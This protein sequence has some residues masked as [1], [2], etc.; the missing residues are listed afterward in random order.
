MSSDS[1]LVQGEKLSNASEPCAK[2]GGDRDWRGLCPR[3]VVETVLSNGEPTFE[4]GP[5]SKIGRYRLIRELGRGGMGRVFLAYQDDLRREVALKM[6]HSGIGPLAGQRFQREA[7][8][9]SRLRHPGIISIYEIGEA[10]GGMFLAMEYVRGQTLAD[11]L[12]EG[13]LPVREAVELAAAVSDAVQHAHDAGVIHR[14]V[15]PSN[16]LQDSERNNAPR[17][18]DFGIARLLGASDFLLTRTLEGIG[19]LSYV[20]PDCQRGEQGPCTDIYALGA[21][22]YHCLTGRP[23][24]V[25]STPAA[26]IRQII[27]NDPPRPSALNAEV[28]ADLDAICLR[29]L[30]K[31]AKRRF[32]SAAE[33]RDDLKRFLSGEPVRTHPPRPMRALWRFS[34]RR[35]AFSAAIAT[36]A[37]ALVVGTS[38]LGVEQGRT[39]AALAVAE[40]STS[41]SFSSIGSWLSPF[42]VLS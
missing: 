5:G 6:L 13:P 23:P 27:E 24:F 16:I 35:P 28:P 3:C 15:K 42:K 34:C 32:S 29:A 40:I 1:H 30:E 14:D 31:S 2:C 37:A 9:T 22:L 7:V 33:L 19:T 20:S 12:Q 18:S 38:F 4:P 26:V 8:A 11:R 36:G 10:A 21:V 17:L 41:A 25:G 39:R